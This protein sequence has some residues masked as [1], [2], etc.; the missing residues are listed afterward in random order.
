MKGIGMN[1]DNAYVATSTGLLLWLGCKTARPIM[2]R[3]YRE[4]WHTQYIKKNY[5]SHIGYKQ[6]NSMPSVFVSECV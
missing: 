4:V 5:I 2:T 6:K 1:K 3:S